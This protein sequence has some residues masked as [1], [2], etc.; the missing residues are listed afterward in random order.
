M[1]RSPSSIAFSSSATAP[2]TVS[3]STR[4]RSGLGIDE[5]LDLERAG[6]AFLAL[7]LGEFLF[8]DA[9]EDLA[10]GGELGPVED[11]QHHVGVGGPEVDPRRVHLGLT[12][13]A[14]HDS[15]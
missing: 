15:F 4:G 2:A 7:P 6:L 13:D 12:N 5:G 9:L 14:R 1:I 8:V 11:A 3:A 10:G